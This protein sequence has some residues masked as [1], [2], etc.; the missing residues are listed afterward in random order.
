MNIFSV[1]LHILF[2]L[3]YIWPN[4]EGFICFI[5]AEAVKLFGKHKCISLN[6]NWRDKFE[7]SI[8]SS[9]HPI[10]YP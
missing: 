1:S 7:T 8:I 10:D 6:K 2:N 5:V 4:K 3:A 9:L